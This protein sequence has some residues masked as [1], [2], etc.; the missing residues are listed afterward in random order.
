MRRR[1][2]LAAV[3]ALLV[4][5]PFAATGSAGG[6]VDGAPAVE[7]PVPPAVALAQWRARHPETGAA[8]TA[9][10]AAA[11]RAGPGGEGG[12]TLTVT[13]S[14]DLV[15]GDLVRLR[16]AG[17]AP[18]E[19]L[20]A[21]Y[22]GPAG[23][24]I[25]DC[26]ILAGADGYGGFRAGP[27]GGF[28]DP[29]HLDV[30]IDGVGA[31]SDC[32][33]V[34]CRVWVLG[35]QP[36]A[37]RS[38]PVVFDP[39]G[40]D[41]TRH[42]VT[43]VPDTGLV[44]GDPLAVT[45]DGFPVTEPGFGIARTLPCRTPVQS[46]ADCDVGEAQ[47]LSVDDDGHAEGTVVA[48]AVLGLSGGAHD[49]RLGGCAL[50]V[51]P[52]NFASID[53]LGE[54][55][56]AAIAPLEF[57]SGG[58]LRP[59]PTLTAD[60]DTDL[61][62]GDAVYL[63]GA[64]FDPNRGFQVAQCLAGATS[65][66][67]CE[68]GV[69]SFGW[70]DDTGIIEGYLGVRATFRDRKDRLVDCRVTACSIVIG[71]GDL[72]RHAEAV[73]TFDPDGELLAPAITVTPSTDLADGD[74]VTVSGTGWPADVGSF[75]LEILQCPADA[76][77]SFDCWP[78]ET[79]ETEVPTEHEAVP[80]ARTAAEVQ[81]PGVSFETT[82]VVRAVLDLEFGRVDCRIEDCIVLAEDVSG[83]RSARAPIRFGS[84]VGPISATP[85]FTG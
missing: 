79:V 68:G 74:V 51:M 57:D 30:I 26:E 58:A 50:V 52:E 81:N 18:R 44:D 48:A 4:A 9:L 20:F 21:V 63:E 10:A 31:T 69:F 6:Q 56:E 47:F 66:E 72:G 11:G 38:A 67:A 39:A 33:I 36:G 55:S 41:P 14:T 22:C 46:S 42:M 16:G 37:V 3:A 84:A 73:L 85:P 2:G 19:A 7:P 78:A 43:V 23:L 53:G 59:A 64:G 62:D 80:M 75:G 49:C 1:W 83:G 32:R 70:T 45:G 27:N 60:P 8:A 65:F 34:T 77:D 54:L 28:S 12:R 24:S 76:Y 40:P 25:D 61:L 15:H 35:E 5:G 13:P 17:W 29:E 82:L 71:H